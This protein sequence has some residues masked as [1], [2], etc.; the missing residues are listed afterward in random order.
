MPERGRRQLVAVAVAVARIRAAMAAIPTI[1]AVL[2][3]GAMSACT[4]HPVSAPDHG[5]DAT[6]LS[7]AALPD[8]GTR[9]PD[10][11]VYAGLSMTTGKPSYVAAAGRRM[12]DGSVYAGISPDT[13]QPLYTTAADAP[14]AYTWNAALAYCRALSAGGHDDWRLPTLTELALQFSNRADI[15]G[16]NETG[17][18]DNGTGYYWSSLQASDSEAW[19]QRFNDGFHEHPGKDIGSALRCVRSAQ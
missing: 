5:G 2:M 4:S 9:M 19:A 1:A 17:S 8:I 7:S 18:M 13:D 15:G 11:T 16:Y 3:I 12:P 10:G 6:P 14:G